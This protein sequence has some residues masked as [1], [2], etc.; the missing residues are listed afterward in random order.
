VFSFHAIPEDDLP[1]LIAGLVAL[2]A[3]RAPAE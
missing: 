3:S 1:A 2:V